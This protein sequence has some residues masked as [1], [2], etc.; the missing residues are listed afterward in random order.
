SVGVSYLP[1]E[2]LALN[3]TW[4]K[5][6][7]QFLTAS[8]SSK[9]EY[10]ALSAEIGPLNRWTFN[11][12]FYQMTTQSVL[13]EGFSGTPGAFT[14]QP[15]GLAF[16][17]SYAIAQNQSLFAEWQRTDLRGYLASRDTLF[18][19]G[20]EYRITRNLSFVL[21]YRFREQLNL[22]PQYRQY[23]YRA[24]SLDANLNFQF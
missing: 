17:A 10:L 8:G 14:Q 4:S 9:N 12:N 24:R 19:F 15:V 16:R 13:G 23:S 2:W 7:V 22:D 21:S 3:A 1:F 20:Y 5:Q 6:D 11:L 18:N